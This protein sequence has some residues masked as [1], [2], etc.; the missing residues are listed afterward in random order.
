MNFGLTIIGIEQ[1]VANIGAGEVQGGPDLIEDAIAVEEIATNFVVV[2]LDLVQDLHCVEAGECHQNQESTE[3]DQQDQP[4]TGTNVCVRRH[5]Y[6]NN[7]H[8]NNAHNAAGRERSLPPASASR[9]VRSTL[10]RAQ[11]S[12]PRAICSAS[13]RVPRCA[14]YINNAHNAAGRERSLPPAS[15]SRAVRSTLIRAQRSGPRAI[16]SASE[17]VP[18]CALYTNTRTTQRAASVLFRQRARPALCALHL[19]YSAVTARGRKSENTAYR[20]ARFG[21]ADVKLAACGGTAKGAM[22]QVGKLV[23]PLR[24]M[25]A[26]TA[27][28]SM[29]KV[30]SL[31]YSVR[32][33]PMQAARLI[34]RVFRLI[35]HGHTSLDTLRD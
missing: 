25:R 31:G 33:L 14:L 11:R 10:T 34:Q 22:T 24:W 32:C 16:C 19:L 2:G 3:A 35:S 27:G 9:A 30:G 28:D 5:L 29:T 17:R 26:G 20:R 7:A 21:S 18:R 23:C 13:G 15:A 4:G 6:I 1:V 12:G 8:N